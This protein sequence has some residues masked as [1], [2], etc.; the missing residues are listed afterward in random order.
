MTI[1]ADNDFI[2]PK[3]GIYR[4]LLNAQD[5]RDEAIR[6]NGF[7]IEEGEKILPVGLSDF[8][9]ILNKH[10]VEISWNTK[11]EQNNHYFSIERSDNGE[12]FHEIG[13]VTG[14]GN[15]NTLQQYYFEDAKPISGKNYYRLKQVDFSALHS[16]SNIVVLSVGNL[17]EMGFRIFPNPVHHYL[18]IKLPQSN[19]TYRAV[20]MNVY[21]RI[22]LSST[23]TTDVLSKDFS[24]RISQLAKGMYFLHVSRN[25]TFYSSGFYKY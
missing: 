13:R 19:E 25:G 21:G 23:G 24:S 17:N 15:S 10:A 6:F 18:Q 14:V 2:R 7:S 12:Q 22:I 9:A 16:F 1:R 8:K 4:S 20:V 11:S 5:L 3:W